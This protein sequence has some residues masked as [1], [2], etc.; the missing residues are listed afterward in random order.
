MKLLPE[1]VYKL[2]SQALIYPVSD[3]QKKKKKKSKVQAN[4]VKLKTANL[5]R[6]S[7]S[8]PRDTQQLAISYD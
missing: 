1:M 2:L 7:R 4:F 3:H 6:S 8:Q 5:L